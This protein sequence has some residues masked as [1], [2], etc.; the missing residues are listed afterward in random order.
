MY[1]ILTVILVISLLIVML[2]I[3]LNRSQ[4]RLLREINELRDYYGVEEFVEYF[5]QL[6]IHPEFVR[7]VHREILQHLGMNDFSVYPEDTLQSLGIEDDQMHVI[8]MSVCQQLQLPYVTSD[9]LTAFVN[10]YGEVECINDLVEFL[11]YTKLLPLTMTDNH[12]SA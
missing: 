7:L 12:L 8:M 6:G 10:T 9:E 4:K 5:E 11:Y 1:I 3:Y 2:L